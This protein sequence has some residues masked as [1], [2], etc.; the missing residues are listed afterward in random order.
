MLRVPSGEA[1]K[2]ESCPEWVTVTPSSGVGRTEVT[3]TVSEMPR[4]TDTFTFEEMGTYGN[5]TTETHKGRAGE[6][7]FLLESKDRRVTMDVQ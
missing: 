6:I 4:T 2:V 3:I 1:W 5:W 7:V